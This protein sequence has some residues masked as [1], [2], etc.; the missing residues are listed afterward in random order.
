[1]TET[2]AFDADGQQLTNLI[3]DNLF[4]IEFNFQE[5]VFDASDVPG[6]IHYKFGTGFKRKDPCADEPLLQD[7]LRQA[8][9]GRRR[10]SVR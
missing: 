9:A 1:M 4:Y 5:L 7:H 10:Y 6:K 8:D 2:H 3:M